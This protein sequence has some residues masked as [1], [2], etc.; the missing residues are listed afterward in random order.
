MTHCLYCGAERDTEQCLSCGLLPAAAE[1]LLRRVLV[2]RTAL[3]LVG[4]VLFV[5]AC[6]AFPPVEVDAVLIFSGILFFIVLGLGMWMINRARRRQEIEVLKRIYFGFLPAPW[7]LAGLLFL[8]GKLDT[9][10]PRRETTSVIAKF[11]MPGVLRTQR[12]VVRSWREGRRVE[13]VLVSRDDYNRFQVGN[14]VV[15]EVE[16]GLAGIPWVYAVYRP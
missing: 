5:P 12:L 4:A 16:E 13:R 6:Q 11:S 3:F 14:D 1:V 2:R 7:I 9:K 15:V 10:P 8:N